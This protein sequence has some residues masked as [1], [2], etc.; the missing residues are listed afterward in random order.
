MTNRLLPIPP[1]PPPGE[2]VCRNCDDTGFVDQEW[3]DEYATPYRVTRESCGECEYGAADAA[4]G[5]RVERWFWRVALSAALLFGA[6]LVGYAVAN[7]GA[8]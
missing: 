2:F 3:C 8:K 1:C 5:R 4:K 7:G 6:F